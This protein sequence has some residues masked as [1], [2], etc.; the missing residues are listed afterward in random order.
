M[1]A[2]NALK[3][4]MWAE[5][6]LDKRR[7]KEEFVMKMQYS[8]FVSNK[9]EPNIQVEGL[10]S[11]LPTV[12]DKNGLPSKKPVVQQ[13]HIHDPQNDQNYPTHVASEQNPAMLEFSACTDNTPLLQPGYAAE[14]SR[15]QLKAYI[16]YRAEEMYVYR[17]LP[18]GQ[19]RRRNRYWQFITSASRNDPGSGRIF[20]ELRNGRWRLIDSEEVVSLFIC[21]SFFFFFFKLLLLSTTLFLPPPPAPQKHNFLF[22]WLNLLLLHS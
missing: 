13:E 19:D 2:A 7:M 22:I 1:E 12:D 18:L 11:P 16:G 14:R 5:V 6:Q 3:K 10:Q 17:S 9:A 15:S 4:Q 21:T 8:S 20:V